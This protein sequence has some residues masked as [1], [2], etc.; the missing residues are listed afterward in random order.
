MITPTP[1]LSRRMILGAF[2]TAPILW[3]LPAIAAEP[4]FYQVDGIA[5]DG[6]DPV[7]YFTQ[8]RAVS[9]SAEFALIW[10]GATWHFASAENRDTFEANPMKYAPQ[11]GGYCSYAAANGALA[12]SDPEAFT[13]HNGKLYLNYSKSVRRRWK[14][15]IDGNIAKAEANWPGLLD[16]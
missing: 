14:R 2:A 13:I 3:A 8:D 5:L 4:A 10:H 6:T 9:G 16:Q 7:A 11:F 1:N 15:D 12:K